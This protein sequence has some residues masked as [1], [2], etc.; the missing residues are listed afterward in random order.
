M[1]IPIEISPLFSL[2]VM[3]YSKTSEAKLPPLK[4]FS[5]VAPYSKNHLIKFFIKFINLIYKI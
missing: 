1:R 2:D 4:K 3:I 5:T